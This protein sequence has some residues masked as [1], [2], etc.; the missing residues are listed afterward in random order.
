MHFNDYPLWLNLAIFAVAAA[1]TWLVG[2][3]LAV[4]ADLIAE[5]TGLGKAFIGL[6]LLAVAT[7][8]PELSTTIAA[9]RLGSY[10]MAISNIFG[11]NAIDVSLVF[12]ADTLYRQGPILQAVDR[13]SM[14]V[15]LAGIVLTCVYLVGLIER[16]DRVVLRMGLDSA[17]VLGLYAGTL[18][19]LYFTR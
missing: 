5:R 12:L 1:V 18:V 13:S 7:S 16:R 3:R 15:A 10:S 2:T 19:V 6:V 4:Y 14:F 8:L 11:S 17:A 9:V